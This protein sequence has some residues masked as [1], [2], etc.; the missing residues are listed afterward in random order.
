M[1]GNGEGSS[2][3][4][5]TLVMEARMRGD[6]RQQAAMFSYV[7]PEARVPQDHPLRAIRI[8]VDE[9]LAELSPR[10]QT[11]VLPGGPSVDPA[12]EAAAGPVAPGALYGPQ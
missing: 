10:F 3:M 7:S 12:R 1:P 2:T 8:L 5:V 11:L 6:D 9:V 4:R